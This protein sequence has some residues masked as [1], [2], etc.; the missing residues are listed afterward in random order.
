MPRKEHRLEA[1][2]THGSRDSIM[3]SRLKAKDSEKSTV[4]REEEG[5]IEARTRIT[6]SSRDSTMESRLDAKSSGKSTTVNTDKELV[7]YSHEAKSGLAYLCKSSF[8]I[9]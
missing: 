5:G 9:T 4:N 6:H 1:R 8:N 7:N 2:T 3:E